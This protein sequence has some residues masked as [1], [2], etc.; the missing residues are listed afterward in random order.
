MIVAI[1]IVVAEMAAEMVL[2]FDC[3]GDLREDD[4]GGGGRDCS[5]RS[6][7]KDGFSF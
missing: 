2:A 4:D 6:C 1:V 5:G 7:C 3:S